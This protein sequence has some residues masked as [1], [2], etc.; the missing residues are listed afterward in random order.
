MTDHPQFAL[1]PFEELR[2][3]TAEVRALRDAVERA[4]ITP[5]PEWV[6]IPQAAAT[7]GCSV[8]TIRRRID[9]GELEAKGNGKLRRVRV[10]RAA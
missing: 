8:P 9:S 6:T 3:L 4:T 5:M 10:S 1:V 7:L 2:A